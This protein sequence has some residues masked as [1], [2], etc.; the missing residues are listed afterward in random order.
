VDIFRSLSNITTIAG[1][2]L[3]P[4]SR[5]CRRPIRV[6]R[7]RNSRTGGASHPMQFPSRSVAF[8]NTG[9]RISRHS[10]PSSLEDNLVTASVEDVFA[11][12][13]ATQ[14]RVVVST[15]CD[16]GNTVRASTL[17]PTGAYSS[18]TVGSASFLVIN[19]T[20]VSPS[21]ANHIPNTRT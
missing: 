3:R 19:V 20:V 13:Y 14:M 17:V 12:K 6:E 16:T 7:G 11:S 4:S 8:P 10:S 5:S 18:S 9:D 2:G 1:E 15:C 21:S